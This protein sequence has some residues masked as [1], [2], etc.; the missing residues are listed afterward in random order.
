MAS[1]QFDLL[2]PFGT[3]PEDK[4]FRT[5]YKWNRAKIFEWMEKV[6]VAGGVEPGDQEARIFL[7]AIYNRLRSLSLPDGS[8]YKDPTKQPS[9]HIARLLDQ[10]WKKDDKTNSKFIVSGWSFRQS[11]QTFKGPVPD[12]WCAYDLLGLFLSLLGPAPSAADKNNFYLPLT[13]VY[14][15]W[16]SRIAGHPESN[17]NWTP[18]VQGEGYLPF[19][20]Q[21]TWHV[22]VDNSTKQHRGQYFLGAT[23]AGDSFVS[24]PNPEKY[25]ASW[26]ER[27]QEARFNALFRC[28]KLPMVQINDFKN[29]AAPNMNLPGRNM[30]PFGNCAETYPF[31][32]RFL[33]ERTQNENLMTGL[34]LKRDFMEKEE[35]P[36]YDEFSTSVIWKNLM[37]PCAN[38][39]GKAPKRPK[40]LLEA[41]K[42]LVEN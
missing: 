36:E 22:E 34:A 6:A 21:C 11:M 27:V 29:R 31:A 25:P 19:V 38:Y 37:G 33:A 7:T 39:K 10:D 15:R 1:P 2:A 40:S 24:D 20:F 26:Q 41:E 5:A 30:V 13:A 17:W 18:D 9:S 23:T 8:L 35:Y 16:C 4:W 32:V 3:N 42:L 14:A 28:Q 12:W